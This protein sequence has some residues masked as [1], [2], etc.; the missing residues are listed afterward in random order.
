MC[1][2]FYQYLMQIKKEYGK[3]WKEE[4]NIIGTHKLINGDKKV[5]AHFALAF[6]YFE[7]VMTVSIRT[8]LN[9]SRRSKCAR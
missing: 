9:A 4:E 3:Y 5:F 8:C 7:Y 2:T 1:N 6:E